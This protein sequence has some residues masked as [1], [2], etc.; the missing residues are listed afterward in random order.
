VSVNAAPP[1]VALF[2]LRELITGLTVR[3]TA[4]E[5]TPPDAT[6]ITATPAKTSRFAGT[7]AVN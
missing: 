5:V 1:A 6:V 3:P 4:F 7:A 2:G